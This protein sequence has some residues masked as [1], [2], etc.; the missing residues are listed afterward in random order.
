MY[1]AG[2]D[3]NLKDNCYFVKLTPD[4]FFWVSASNLKPEYACFPPSKNTKNF[5][6]TQDLRGGAHGRVWLASTSSGVGCV[7]KF[8]QANVQKDLLEHEAVLWNRLWNMPA[9]IQTLGGRKALV[10]PYVFQCCEE[11]RRSP[12]SCRL[13]PLR[14]KGWLKVVTNMTT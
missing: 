1:N 9:R 13:S 12:R 6:L 11:D 2:M 10:M 3:E 5:L 4:S 7:L 8:Q 14:F